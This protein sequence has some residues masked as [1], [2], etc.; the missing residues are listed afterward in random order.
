MLRKE[1]SWLYLEKHSPANLGRYMYFNM[2]LVLSHLK[3]CEGV[4]LIKF[5][6][7]VTLVTNQSFRELLRKVKGKDKSF[8][9]NGDLF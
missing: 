3:G 4:S 5:S 6:D 1:C 9:I 7:R 2:S 8:L